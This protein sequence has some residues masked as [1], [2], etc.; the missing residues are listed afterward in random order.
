MYAQC[1]MTYISTILTQHRHG[2]NN[3]LCC[4]YYR[5]PLPMEGAPLEEDFDAF[6]NI[7]RVSACKNVNHGWKRSTNLDRPFLVVLSSMGSCF[8]VPLKLLMSWILRE[9]LDFLTEVT[10]RSL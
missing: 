9:H 6:V 8:K 1:V 7:L 5:V 4:R 10:R 3:L 2:G